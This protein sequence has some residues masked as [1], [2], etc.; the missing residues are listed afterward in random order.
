MASAIR[1]A[2]GSYSLLQERPAP[3][4]RTHLAI[5]TDTTPRDWFDALETAYPNVVLIVARSIRVP[6][7]AEPMHRNQWVD[8]RLRSDVSLQEMASLLD[9]PDAQSRRY[10]FPTVPESLDRFASPR[11]VK[12]LAGYAWS[13]GVFNVAVGTALLVSA[14]P[15]GVNPASWGVHAL[16]PLL[17]GGVFFWLANRLLT[18]R[19]TASVTN[20]C[21]LLADGGMLVF[22]VLADVLKLSALSAVIGLAVT[23]LAVLFF[24]QDSITTWL[25]RRMHWHPRLQQSTLAVPVGR[26]LWGR[27]LVYLL[28]ALELLVPFAQAFLG[29][30]SSGQVA[31]GPAS[32]TGPGGVVATYAPP[33]TPP[34]TSTVTASPQ[35]AIRQFSLPTAQSLPQAIAVGP[36]GNLWVGETYGNNIARITPVGTVKEFPLPATQVAPE[37]M[38]RGP[39]GN[40]WFLV[41]GPPQVGRITPHGVITEFPLPDQDGILGDLVV[42]HD[43]NLWFTEMLPQL[44]W[45]LGRITP[46]GKVTEFPALDQLTGSDGVAIAA[47]P[48]GNLWLMGSTSIVRVSSAGQV[49]GPPI[50]ISR[51]GPIAITQ[52]PDRNMWFV[53]YGAT[54][55]KITLAGTVTTYAIGATNAYPIAMT[56]GVKGD[57]WFTDQGT[58]SIGH[59]SSRGSIIEI[60]IPGAP[61]KLGGIVARPDGSVWFT[62]PDDNQVGELIPI[63][64]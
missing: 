37:G 13:I 48:D 56:R 35:F 28:V 17:I 46:E 47:G 36:D 25:P 1:T 52:G 4:A 61:S 60:P 41:G 31:N 58:A 55:G 50:D 15:R 26:R 7:D 49:V 30:G 43:G 45:R 19:V 5:I 24:G 63:I 42:G 20:L 2:M 39:D 23:P 18:A 11:T 59:I 9:K 57:L 6:H 12:V 21:F 54:V 32:H 29:T 8:Y 64:A 16:V 40:L 33:L 14:F 62:E 53:G 10:P 34:P 38:V 22:G 27:N 51:W 3:A 44:Y